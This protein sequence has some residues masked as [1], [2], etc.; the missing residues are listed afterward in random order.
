MKF[1]K[2][3]AA[4]THAQGNCC[5]NRQLYIILQLLSTHFL[6]ALSHLLCRDRQV[7]IYFPCLVFVWRK[8][9]W[10]G[11]LLLGL[12]SILEGIYGPEE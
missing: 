9:S 1:S 12:V 5:S 11:Q 7:T 10:Y 6:S 3:F 2:H 4:I 8:V